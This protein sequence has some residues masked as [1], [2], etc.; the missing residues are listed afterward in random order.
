MAAASDPTA[1][2]GGAFGGRG[3]PTTTRARLEGLEETQV[4]EGRA[5]QDGRQ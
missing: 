1:R 3:M 2:G 5:V 4:G